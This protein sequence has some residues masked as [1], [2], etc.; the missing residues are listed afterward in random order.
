MYK[1]SFFRKFFSKKMIQ[2]EDFVDRWSTKLFFLN[3]GLDQDRACVLKSQAILNFPQFLSIIDR[4][5]V[6]NFSRKIQS[7]LDNRF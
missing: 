1:E 2:R 4:Q 3:T 7:M 5:S 6:L